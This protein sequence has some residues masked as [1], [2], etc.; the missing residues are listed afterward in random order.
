LAIFALTLHTYAVKILKRKERKE[1]LAKYAKVEAM[2]K[3]KRKASKKKKSGARR[4]KVVATKAEAKH[5][6]WDALEMEEVNPLFHR[7]FVYGEHMLMARLM[8]KKGCLVPLHHHHNEQVSYVVD[9]A[10]K[11]TFPNKEVVV[12]SGEVLVIPPNLPHKVEALVDTLDFDI[13]S[14][15][16]A[17]WISKS[18]QYLREGKETKTPRKVG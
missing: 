12:N 1:N 16:R 2:I 6:A 18:D 13:F 10:L 11:F 14:P 8:L 9:G 17:D 3:S 15:P 4:A 5:A 7:H